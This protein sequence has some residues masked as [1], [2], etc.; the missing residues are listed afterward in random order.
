[1]TDRQVE[2]DASDC[3]ACEAD[4]AGNVV[5]YCGHHR[6]LFDVVSVHRDAR[7]REAGRKAVERG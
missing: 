5:G 2:A 3:S 1:M 6:A 7:Y 4:D